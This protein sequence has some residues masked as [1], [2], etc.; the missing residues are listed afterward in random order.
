MQ[1]LM[2]FRSVFIKRV[3]NHKHSIY[4]IGFKR[5]RNTSGKCSKLTKEWVMLRPLFGAY[6]TLLKELPFAEEKGYTK[7][8]GTFDESFSFIETPN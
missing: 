4:S 1:Q 7:N 8:P 6:D 2:T 5:R 3:T